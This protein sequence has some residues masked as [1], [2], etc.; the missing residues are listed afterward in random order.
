[1][2][3][4]GIANISSWLVL[5]VL[6]AAF[7]A[8]RAMTLGQ[9]VDPSWFTLSFLGA[10]ILVEWLLRYERAVSQR[11]VLVRD[12]LSTAVNLYLTGVLASMVFLAVLS[13]LPEFFFGRRLVFASPRLLGPVWLQIP[14][15]MLA[16][17]LFR[18]WLHRL[19]H[20]VPFLWELHSYHHRVTDVRTSNLFVSHPFDY[21]LRNIL[22]FVVLALIG[23]NR[24]AIFV[25]LAPLQVSAAFS[26]CGGDV[27]GGVFNYF[28]ATPEVHRWHHSAKVPDGH[29][30]SVNY[31]VELSIWDLVF[32]TFY[33]PMRN[34]VP[35][36]PE[37]MGHPG[38]L[39]DE[40]NYLKLLL[41]P[42]G[43]Y[44]LLGW[45]SGRRDAVRV[46]G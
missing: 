3:T 43:V 20:S 18:Y 41:A 15:I 27:K 36:Q 44:R 8:I 29:K 35:E 33:L 6:F 16:V 5:P 13:G 17:S 34:G 10:M 21:A 37:R 19:Q 42:L 38:G 46:E 1:M 11:P 23:F 31:G 12:I 24:F 7:F 28:F 4:K 22:V 9:G 14:I 39:P 40:P 32:G 30:Y 2:S 26:H 45:F 25:A